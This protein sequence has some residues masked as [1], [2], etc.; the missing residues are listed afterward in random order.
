[1][2]CLTMTIHPA[3]KGLA[4]EGYRKFLNFVTDFGFQSPLSGDDLAGH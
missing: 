2:D 1:M 4:S 3:S